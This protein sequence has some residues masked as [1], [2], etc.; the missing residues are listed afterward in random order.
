MNVKKNS[1]V[2][3][4][5]FQKAAVK[6]TVVVERDANGIEIK[7]KLFLFV[8]TT[9][10]MRGAM[11]LTN[12]SEVNIMKNIGMVCS[13]RISNLLILLLPFHLVTLTMMTS[14]TYSKSLRH[15]SHGNGKNQK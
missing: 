15:E 1:K 6:I 9:M 11:K 5:S 12:F 7:K 13:R 8:K 3:I 4:L 2:L 14:V 10:T